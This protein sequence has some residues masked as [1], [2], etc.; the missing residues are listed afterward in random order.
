MKF[1]E[2][3]DEYRIPYLAEG[4]EHCRSGWIQLDCILCNRPGHYRLGYNLAKGYLSCWNCGWVRVVD[5]LLAA[6]GLPYGRVRALIDGLDRIAGPPRQ[7]HAGTL[8]LPDF[9]EPMGPAHRKYLK[10]RGFDPDEIERL[11]G[12]AGIGQTPRL[13][14]RLFIPIIHRSE[15]VSWTTRSIA[16]GDTMRYRSA[17]VNEEKLPHKELLYGGDYVKHVAIIVEGPLD[18]WAIGPGAVA[19]CGT[20]YSR[21][22]LLQMALYPTRVVLFDTERAARRR[23]SALAN[24]LMVFPGKTYNVTLSAKDAAAASKA[25]IKELRKRF[26]E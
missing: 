5:Y 17:G 25:D 1:T 20:A 2:L 8:K 3:L 9:I 7:R 26:L 22:Q 23:A 11:W 12:V 21:R 6:L 16:P 13:G 4:H 14:W 10:G 24:D 19:T 18:V 15:T